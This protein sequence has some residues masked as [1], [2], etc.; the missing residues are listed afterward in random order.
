MA[1]T[2]LPGERGPRKLDDSSRLVVFFFF[3]VTDFPRF[4]YTWLTLAQNEFR[5]TRFGE[6]GQ[7]FI[8]TF[9]A[10]GPLFLAFYVGGSK[11]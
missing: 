6:H 9:S 10:F 7:F 5:G 4:I 2:R 3:L 8:P 1:T 11:F